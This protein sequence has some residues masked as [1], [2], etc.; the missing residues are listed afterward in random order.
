MHIFTIIFVFVAISLAI[1]YL[2]LKKCQQTSHYK[3][4]PC[5]SPFSLFFAY[6]YS[7]STGKTFVQTLNEYYSNGKGV[8]HFHVPF[9]K[10]VALIT[11]N[12]HAKVF[13]SQ[14]ACDLAS[15][16]V[17]PFN[18]AGPRA[19]KNLPYYTPVITKALAEKNSS[20]AYALKT[21]I[22]EYIASHWTAD[23][24]VI[25]FFEEMHEMTVFVI[26][27]LLLGS[28]VGTEDIS[29]F[30]KCTRYLDIEDRFSSM[31]RYISTCFLPAGKRK[32]E[33]AYEQCL[34]IVTKLVNKRLQ[35]QDEQP[36][37]KNGDFLSCVI[38]E[39]TSAD[40]TVSYKDIMVVITASVFAG[41][42]NTC[43]T[44]AWSLPFIL[45]DDKLVCV[46]AHGTY[47]RRVRNIYVFSLEIHVFIGKRTILYS[48]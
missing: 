46:R 43:A 37:S 31:N 16:T 48:T 27:R 30:A 26:T 23:V 15:A 6:L 19:F 17:I 9:W 3:H 38:S 28:D 29:E 36:I 1:H 42:T 13:Y 41:T 34:A 2:L 24:Q 40:G 22:E 4:P 11:S 7:Q 33:E 12:E 20:F 44:I 14:K 21:E 25:D 18:V 45:S 32:T 35:E 47:M 39:F 8:I 5:I 10:E